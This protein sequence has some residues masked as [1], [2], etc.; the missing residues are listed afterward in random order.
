MMEGTQA[1]TRRHW[2]NLV[3]QKGSGVAMTQVIDDHVQRCPPD[4]LL[5]VMYLMNRLKEKS[6]GEN[7]KRHKKV[8]YPGRSACAIW[9]I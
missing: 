8:S 5:N 2:P 7:K 4:L 3:S 1:Y 9:V 6:Q